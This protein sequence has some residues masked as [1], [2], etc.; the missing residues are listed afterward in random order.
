MI[1]VIGIS[2]KSGTGKD[3]IYEKCFKPKGYFRFALAD[4]LKIWSMAQ[5]NFTYEEVFITKPD[6]V[7]KT[8]QQ[9]GTEFGRDKY[10]KD[11]WLN[12][13]S[14]WMTHLNTT[15]GITKFCI[16]DVR[17][18]NEVEYIYSK[19]NGMVYRIVAP[20]RASKNKL[21]PEDRLHSSEISLDDYTNFS[22]F[23]YNDPGDNNIV[24]QVD[25]VVNFSRV[26]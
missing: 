4:H 24:D 19:L 15:M 16:T 13:A 18:P 1:D 12:T 2:G 25:L 11:V 26:L 10:G 8:L 5:H 6:H 23:L 9:L 22:G 21:S 17:F 14:S 7:R 3:Y 20:D